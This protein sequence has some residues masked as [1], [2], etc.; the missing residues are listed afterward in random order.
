MKPLIG[1]RCEV[2]AQLRTKPLGDSDVNEA[3]HTYT[4]IRMRDLGAFGVCMYIHRFKVF[5]LNV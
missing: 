2:V 5:F 1:P 4:P 3:T